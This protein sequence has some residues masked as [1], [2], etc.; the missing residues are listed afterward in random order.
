MIRKI[1]I[2]KRERVREIDLFIPRYPKLFELLTVKQYHTNS[3][4]K[5]LTL[6]ESPSVITIGEPDLFFFFDRLFF[7]F[8]NSVI[9]YVL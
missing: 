4:K 5:T 1:K 6:T 3:R 7:S 2:I 8:S 9:I